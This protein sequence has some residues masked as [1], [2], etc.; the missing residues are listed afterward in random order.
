MALKPF[1][2]SGGKGFFV[3]PPTT[4]TKPSLFLALLS[5]DSSADTSTR[6][7]VQPYL[8]YETWLRQ[9]FAKPHIGL[10]GLDGLVS[11]YD[12]YERAFKI[13]NIDREMTTPDKYIMPFEKRERERD[14]ELAIAGSIEEFHE[15]FKAFTHGW[16]SH[17]YF[18]PVFQI[19][20]VCLQMQVSSK[21]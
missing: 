20:Y 7:L 9:A 21:I 13:R 17:C 5:E 4:P 14:G 19:Q 12:G 18:C 6:E 2:T 15:H 16:L 10:D 1:L 8:L 3:E 11:I